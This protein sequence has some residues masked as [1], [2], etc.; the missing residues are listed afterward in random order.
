MGLPGMTN[1]VSRLVR[2]PTSRPASSVMGMPDV[3]AAHQRLGVGQRWR[4]GAMW[5][6]DD[7]PRLGRLT[8]STSSACSSAVRFAVNDTDAAQARQSDS[9]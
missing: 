4:P 5:W 7:H 2:M 9:H 1:R 3:I 8:L 6:I